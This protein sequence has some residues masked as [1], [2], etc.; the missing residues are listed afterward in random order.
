MMKE[1]YVEKYISLCSMLCK[2][3]DDYN[4]NK[5]NNHNK[6]IRK[7]ITLREELSKNDILSYKVYSILLEN[8]DIYIRQSAATECLNLNIHIEKS[9]QLLEYIIQKGERMASM[10]AERTLKIWRG[11]IKP[12]DPF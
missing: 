2:S 10:G 1:E 12:T 5:V 3:P 6:A 4:K 7:L 11:E 8:A 9:E